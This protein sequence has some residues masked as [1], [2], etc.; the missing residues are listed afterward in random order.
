MFRAMISPIFRSTRLCVTDCGI[1]HPR[2]RWTVAWKRRNSV[3][4]PPAGIIPV[5]YTTSCNTQFN[6]PDDGQNHHPKHVEMIEII[7]KPLLLHLIG[8]LYYLYQRYTVKKISKLI[9]AQ[10]VR[11][12]LTY[13][14]HKVHYYVTTSPLVPVLQQMIQHT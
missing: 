7:N 11:K 14:N 3:S 6:A 8:C 4:K 9:F 12:C 1:M 5:I 13:R 2:C 10:L